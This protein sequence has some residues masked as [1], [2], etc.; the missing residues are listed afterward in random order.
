MAIFDWMANMAIDSAG[1]GSKV[2]GTKPD[3]ANYVPTDLS[4]ESKKA[5]EANISNLPEIQALL[6]KI[7]PGWSEMEKQGSANTLALLRGELPKDVEDKVRRTSAF[8]SFTGGYGGSGMSKALTARDFGKTSLDLM[9]QGE[10]SAQRWMGMT[11][12]AVSPWII[13]GKEQA[14]QTMKNNLYQQAVDQF[15]FNV[16]ASADPASAGLFNTISTIGGT[17]ASFGM[18][19]AMGAQ[20]S[21]GAAATAPAGGGGGGGAGVNGSSNNPYY[22][23]INSGG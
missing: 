14:D 9:G 10:N 11:E 19:S 23:W 2:F 17:A 5:T 18:G 4:A 7:L 8:K 16:L 15:R 20:R 6:E 3:V 12:G 22:G 21:G 1:G 13:T